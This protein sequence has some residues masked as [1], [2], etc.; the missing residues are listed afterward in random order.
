[1][2]A[3]CSLPRRVLPRRGERDR[4][5]GV[6]AL[7]AG[8]TSIASLVVRGG[9]NMTR[10][11]RKIIITGIWALHL[12][13]VVQVR[14]TPRVTGRTGTLEPWT[15]ANVGYLPPA[16]PLRW[17]AQTGI[18]VL[19]LV[20]TACGSS[21][22]SKTTATAT[23]GSVTTASPVDTASPAA[24]ASPI[25]PPSPIDVWCAGT[26]GTGLQAVSTDLDQIQTD[27]GN[28]DLPA[29][30]SDGTQLF[31]DAQTAGHDLP[32]GSKKVKLYY[33]LF[34][35]WMMI[36]GYKMSTG[37]VTDANSDISRALQFHSTVK[38]ISGDCND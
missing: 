11:G 34:M 27:S 1:M 22:S 9:T 5:L 36:A 17:R 37:D 24:P 29:I 16:G 13:G 30:E 14:A 19:A 20:L 28:D 3:N 32:P 35:G 18:I 26:G 15:S 21:T 8:V 6:I 25:A 31:N 4:T 10:I 38:T 2:S 7:F 33:G 12:T 23:W